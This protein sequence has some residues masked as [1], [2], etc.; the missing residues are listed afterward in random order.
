M[1]EYRIDHYIPGETTI[2]TGRALYYLKNNL[3]DAILHINPMFCCPGVVT[4]SIYR[5]MQKDF[6][7]PI[8]DIFYDGTGNP[9]QALKPYMEFLKNR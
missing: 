1:E 9:N 2:N 8:I 3:A 7:R 5:Q 4:S 6:G